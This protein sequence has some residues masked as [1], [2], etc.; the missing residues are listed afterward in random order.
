MKRMKKLLAVLLALSLLTALSACSGSS[1]KQQASEPT[2]TESSETSETAVWPEKPVTIIVPYNA[3]GDS[4]FNARALAEKLT[5]A[6]GQSFIVQ[7]V[8]GNSGATGSLQALEADP[9]GYTML[10]NHTAFTINYFSGTSDLTYDDLT[11]GAVCAF[12][13]NTVFVANPAL[14]MTKLS[15]IKAYCDENPGGVIFGGSSGTT[16]IVPGLKMRAAG[17]DITMVDAGG[18]ADR[19]A[20]VLGGHVD[21]VPVPTGNAQDYLATG[22]LVQIEDDLGIEPGCPVYYQFLFPKGTDEAIVA[23][24]NA[25]L[26]EIIFN[27]AEYAESIKNAYQQDPFYKNAEDG[28]ALVADLWD[29]YS[30]LDWEA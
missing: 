8:G 23:E 20:A 5:E 14:G 22:E 1:S 25:L 6:T 3:G 30:Q 19:M 17:L 26:E 4:D 15:E 11:F 28:A 24:L 2:S 7:N 9:D 21:F 16:A 12:L 29:T 10:F 18:T 27:D 13:D